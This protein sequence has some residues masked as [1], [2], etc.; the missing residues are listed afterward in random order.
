ML[1]FCPA[2]EHLNVSHVNVNEI[3]RPT[4]IKRFAFL[5]SKGRLYDV[6]FIIEIDKELRQ[7]EIN[8]EDVKEIVRTK[9]S[10]DVNVVFVLSFSRFSDILLVF[11]SLPQAKNSI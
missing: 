5:L 11:S 7:I 3:V 6:Y 4:K 10:I 1:A 8:V 2:Q 9:S